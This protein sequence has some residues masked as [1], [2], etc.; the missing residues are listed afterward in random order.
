MCIRSCFIALVTALLAVASGRGF[1]AE[2]WTYEIIAETPVGQ[3]PLAINDLGQIAF[4]ERETLPGGMERGAIVLSDGVNRTVLYEE[5]Y[6]VGSGALNVVQ[7]GVNN[8]GEVAFV[9]SLPSSGGVR[10]I[11]R[12]QN[13][14]PR[15]L[16]GGAFISGTELSSVRIN[17]NGQIP[18]S[19]AIDNTTSGLHMFTAERDGSIVRRTPIYAPFTSGTISYTYPTI[20]NVGDLAIG[21]RDQ[22]P[23]QVQT[24]LRIGLRDGGRDDQ[25]IDQSSSPAALGTPS[26]NDVRY[27]SIVTTPNNGTTKT[28]WLIVPE[29]IDGI[30]AGLVEIARTDSELVSLHD[31][32]RVSMYNTVA[33]A[34][35]RVRNQQQVPF[36]AIWD[37]ATR[38]SITVVEMYETLIAGTSPVFLDT[39]TLN[40]YL[41]PNAINERGQIAFR[42][43][44]D[45]RRVIVRATPEPGMLPDA[46][47]MPD[48]GDVLTDGM[49]FPCCFTGVA[50][51]GITT[52]YDPPVAVGYE[53][54]SD[55]P[56]TLRFAQ[57]VIPAPLRGGDA[58]FTV[59]FNGISQPL[60]AGTAF[61]FLVYAPNGVES[62]RIT[63]I[64]IDEGLRPDD[65]Q[66]F[67][68]GL[69]FLPASAANGTFTMKPIVENTD[70]SDGDGV[71]ESQDNCPTVAN[72]DQADSDGDGVGNLCDN[73]PS[74]SNPLQADTDGDGVGDAC[75]VAAPRVCSVDGDGDI[76]RDDIAL[77]T[78]AR[79]QPASGPEDPRDPDRNGRID[80]NDARAC[81]AQCDR[82]NCAIQ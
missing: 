15:A 10:R 79:N 27:A 54:R 65:P 72:P 63:G 55:S 51:P 47:V 39:Q 25:V 82:P 32:T 46:P 13:G 35:I 43:R 77:I 80:V 53:Y 8:E 42:A 75:E 74:V 6:P 4:E 52:Y 31:D 60:L 49:R 33:Y 29:G 21:V 16:G 23:G 37:A 28:L 57:V 20:N 67:V 56:T 1:T 64:D 62:F 9:G 59:E 44:I 61:D 3:H 66:A 69:G 76:D 70:D 58:E 71:I 45:N 26:L 18:F 7:I 68:T 73:C 2:R 19:A 48:P 30:P 36:I 24:R 38:D 41:A 12:I 11:C 40:G 5:V 81:T 34:G 50:G 78:A 14:V 22:F 17:N